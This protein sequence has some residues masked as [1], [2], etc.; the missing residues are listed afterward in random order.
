MLQGRRPASHKAIPPNP[1]THP[2]THPPTPGPTP[3]P[4]NPPAHPLPAHPPPQTPPQL[5]P[6]ERPAVR[7][8]RLRPRARLRHRPHR[9]EPQVLRGGVHQPAL[10][11]AHLQVGTAIGG[12][13]RS[14]GRRGWPA[15]GPFGGASGL[16]GR[17]LRVRCACVLSLFACK[18]PVCECERCMLRACT[19]CFVRAWQWVFALHLG[20]AIPFR[21]PHAPPNHHPTPQGPRQAAPRQRQTQK[22]PGAGRGGRGG[23]RGRDAPGAAGAVCPC[24]AGPRPSFSGL[25]SALSPALN[26]TM[27]GLDG[28]QRERGRVQGELGDSMHILQPNRGFQCAGFAGRW[29]VEGC[30]GWQRRNQARRADGGAR[31]AGQQPP[32]ARRGG[33]ASSQP[34]RAAARQGGWREDCWAEPQRHPH[35]ARKCAS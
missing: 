31:G 18:L 22:H 15:G 7:P 33:A 6:P 19:A 32:K 29:G 26:V 11:D 23:V 30:R 25:L 34:K 10:D 9:R 13:G 4:P 14:G 17:G 2:P 20:A 24:R 21:A 1:P 3:P 28:R 35:I 16:L 8:A 12:V 5:R 27:D